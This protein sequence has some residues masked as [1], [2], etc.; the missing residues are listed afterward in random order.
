MRFSC[1]NMKNWN[2]CP[3][4]RITKVIPGQ[5]SICYTRPSWNLIARPQRLE[6]YLTHRVLRRR[7]CH[8]T[9]YSA[10]DSLQQDLLSIILRF[11]RPQFV[12]IADI[13]QMYRQVLLQEDQWDLQSIIWRHDAKEPV[14]EY[15]FNTVW[16][17]HR[18]WPAPARKR[19]PKQTSWSEQSYT[20]W[21]LRG[22]V[23]R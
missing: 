23:N 10:L 8:S 12:I 1:K 22:F 15:R 9:I 19:Q 7:E 17:M 2:T 6:L 4:S 18:S 5:L 13:K 11:R 14:R 16:P 20:R 3:K 21:F